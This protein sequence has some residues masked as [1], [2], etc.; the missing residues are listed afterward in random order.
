MHRIKTLSALAVGSAV[1]LASFLPLPAV[2]QNNPG[3]DFSELSLEELIQVEISSLGR[4][5][6][7]VFDTP[8]P[9]YIVT[10][11]DIHR[12]GALTLPEVLQLAPGVQVSRINS[13]SYAITIRGFN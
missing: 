6:S 2:A 1:V 7:P 5:S 11:D 9:A 10:G 8:A 4:K 13:A 3:S 12:S